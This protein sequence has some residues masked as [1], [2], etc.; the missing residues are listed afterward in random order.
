MFTRP[1]PPS[2]VRFG[3]FEVNLTAQ[4][5]R[6]HGVQLKIRGQP[7]EILTL[8]LE[9]PG[10]VVTR[11]QLRV[12]L[13]P[14]DTFV[15]FEHGLN[16]AV[17]RLR[18]V[19]G[20]SPENSR[21][22]ETIPRVGY[23]FIAPVELTGN[24][25]R[26][27]TD[28]RGDASSEQATPSTEV[29]GAQVGGMGTRLLPGGTT[30]EVPESIAESKRFTA[31]RALAGGMVVIL[32][33]AFALLYRKSVHRQSVAD[34]GPAPDLAI[35]PLISLPGEEL[36]PAYSPDGS[37]V[38]FVWQALDQ[39]NSGIYAAVVGSQ[40]LMRLS[41]NASDYSPAWSPDGRD[42]AFLR[43]SSDKFFVELVPALGG[44]ETRIYTG[45]LGQFRKLTRN[46]GLSFSPDGKLLVFT[47]WNEATQQDSIRVLSIQDASS[48]FLVATPAS[49]QDRSP[50]F[51]PS[52][53]KVAFVRSSGPIYVDELFVASLASGQTK[54]LTFDHKRIL[55]PPGWTEVA[56][57][58]FRPTERD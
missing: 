37:R 12:R 39:R 44:S 49:F 23:R 20:D 24:R 27:G 58:S 40:S 5:L 26:N 45:S 53:D 8:L 34:F 22:V 50:A 10:E 4:H 54:Q 17:K 2:V 30:R 47:E 18:K 15:D 28:R 35:L 51:S 31:S 57:F 43:D 6:K 48:R 14:A 25:A 56:K 33:A 1:I 52:G 29:A 42:I 3:V 9:K 32:V 21:Y 55:G 41:H 19:L 13:W 11:E 7:F 36:M 38:A 46:T 16:S